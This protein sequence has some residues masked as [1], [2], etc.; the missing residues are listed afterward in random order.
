MA[1]LEK[2]RKNT[3]IL[4]SVVIGLAL[5]AFILGDLAS[6][7]TSL[8]G[9]QNIEV[10]NIE[11]ESVSINEYQQKIEEVT[12][13]YRQNNQTNALDE[14]TN[15]EIR[16][17][18]WEMI[19]QNYI[20]QDEYEKLGLGVS[21]EELFN[22]IQGDNPYPV[23]RQLFGDPE[24]GQINK[25]HLMNFLRALKENRLPKDQ[26]N[27]WLYLEE[28]MMR[29]QLFSKY[30]NLIRKGMYATTQEAQNSYI[31]NQKK[32]DMQYLMLGFNTVNDTA[33]SIAN[34]DMKNF[35]DQHQYKYEQQASRDIRFVTIEIKPSEEDYNAIKNWINDIHNEFREAEKPGQF[36][37]LNSDSSFNP[38]YHKYEELPDT[39]KDFMFNADVG[40]DFG[41]YFEEH[42][43][44]YKI[45]MLNDIKYLPDSVK[46]RHIL[47]RAGENISYEQ[48]KSIA[49]SLKEQLEEGADF[50]ELARENSADGSA[51]E[52]GD[53]GWF[54]P[55]QM[56]KPFSDSCFNAEI[57]E[58][59]L[60]QSRF[61]YHIAQVTDKGPKVKKVQ[62]AI[63]K[64]NVD[65]SAE[66]YDEL[67]A[68]AAQFAGK[69]STLEEFLKAAKE[70]GLIVQ[71]A[72]NIRK[73]NLGIPGFQNAREIIRWA[74]EAEEG[75]TSP[76][77]EISDH[78][79]I[80]ALSKAQEDGIAPFEAVKDQVRFEVKNIKKGEFLAEKIKK[81]KN[82]NQAIEA[83]SE[84]LNTNL[85]LA[86]GISFT[87]YRIPDAGVEPKVIA[88]ATTLDEGIISEPII[89]NGGVYMLSVKNIQQPEEKDN[90][91]FEQS[92][93][94]RRYQA[95]AN[96]EAYEALKEAA[97]IED[98]RLEF[99]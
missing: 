24:T 26:Q 84:N 30:M 29:S 83:I 12:G 93:L 73:N 59:K 15:K 17:Q 76:L 21:S 98:N 50:A 20:L 71:T 43:R 37:N 68:R 97:E 86:E 47:I 25:T 22:L 36:V 5:L 62:V 80:A 32:V 13:I 40:D 65:P 48:A 74:Y 58:L 49:D 81:A 2:L 87:S 42:T 75:A 46:A 54:T 33:I 60:I 23:V 6:S 39:L 79:V 16:E 55:G 9:G 53:L 67:Y 19:L 61:G 89:G 95:R 10:A 8:F 4:I 7:G 72:N 45:A 41:P 34:R 27:F 1:T 90:F 38:R 64:R 35:Y 66:T 56:V 11:G 44:S 31:N 28:E 70:E 92:M 14:E 3:G 85:Q 94:Q 52:G 78:F 69:N 99:Y 63:L 57:G 51:E 88:V 77:F 91:V 18:V 96:Q 82:E